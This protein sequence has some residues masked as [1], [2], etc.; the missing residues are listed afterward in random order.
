MSAVKI[1]VSPSLVINKLTPNVKTA[2]KRNNSYE[3]EPN[4][5]V[6]KYS[7]QTIASTGG[8]TTSLQWQQTIGGSTPTSLKKS[9]GAAISSLPPN[10]I[11]QATAGSSKSES[12]NKSASNVLQ[13]NGVTTFHANGPRPT[14]LIRRELPKR[15][16][17]SVTLEIIEKNPLTHIGVSADRLDLLKNV[18]CVTANVSFIDCYITLKKLRQNEECSLL[19]E[20]FEMTET[21]IQQTFALNITRLARFMRFLVVYPN[22]KKYYDRHKNLPFQFRSDL[23][24]VQSLIDLVETEIDC[25]ELLS[26]NSYKYILSISPNGLI[27]Y[28]SDAFVGNFDDLTIFKSSTFHSC[29][30]K[31]LSL[32]AVPGKGFRNRHKSR[33]VNASEG[34]DTDSNTDSAEESANNDTDNED[35]HKLSRFDAARIAANLVSHQTMSVENNNLVSCKARGYTIPT[36]RVSTPVCREQLRCVLNT[37]REFKMLQHHGIKEPLLYQYINESL[38]VA[39]ALTNLQR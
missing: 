32:V 4:E 16:I 10:T 1:G 35:G 6:K 13:S 21:E 12:S 17:R 28:V 11:I 34:K 29:I 39:A 8:P 31:Y 26:C 18:I 27:C 3:T 25:P 23:S 36:T 14:V 24:H 19:A 38:L 33:K 20:Y 2:V 22:S 7:L 30:P 5:K 9:I 15:T 37:L